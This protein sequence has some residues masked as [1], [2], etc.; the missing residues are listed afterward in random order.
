MATWNPIRLTK[1]KHYCMATVQIVTTVTMSTIDRQ[2]KARQHV[3]DPGKYNRRVFAR[4]YRWTFWITAVEELSWTIK[5]RLARDGNECDSEDGVKEKR[6]RKRITIV[7]KHISLRIP[8]CDLC[9]WVVTQW[10]NLTSNQ[11]KR[12]LSW[13]LACSWTE[14]EQI[15]FE[16]RP[17]ALVSRLVHT[18]GEQ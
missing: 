12:H 9:S 1:S 10:N 8:S 11:T 14:A 4:R 5:M 2:A 18:W 16:Q 13:T 6:A 3:E 15:T 17:L 7:N